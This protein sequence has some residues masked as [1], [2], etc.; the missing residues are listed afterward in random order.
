MSQ[1]VISQASGSVIP[2]PSD[3][4]NVS[5]GSSIQCCHYLFFFEIKCCRCNEKGQV[6]SRIPQRAL[7]VLE[8]ESYYPHVVEKQIVNHIEYSGDEDDLD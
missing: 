1:P 5:H 8:H 2:C 6:A 7:V 4:S 3:L